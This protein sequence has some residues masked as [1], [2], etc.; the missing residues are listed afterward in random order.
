MSFW[1]VCFDFLLVAVPRGFEME[2]AAGFIGCYSKRGYCLV[3]F[4]LAGKLGHGIFQ[5]F[6]LE[7]SSSCKG[8]LIPNRFDM[9][10]LVSR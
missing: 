8:C 10:A 5:I 1:G 4:L 7:N 2:Y 3:T 6:D 9:I